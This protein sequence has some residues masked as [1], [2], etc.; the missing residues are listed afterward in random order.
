VIY[1][2]NCRLGDLFENRRQRGRPGLPLLSVTMNDGLVDRDDLE[3][4]QACA[5]IWLH[6]G[7]DSEFYFQY[8]SAQYEAIRELGNAGTQQNLN[9]AI[10][11]GLVVPVPPASEQ[12]RIVQ[13]LSTVDHAIRLSA[14]QVRTLKDEKTALMADLLT[15]KRRVR[16]PAAE[17]TP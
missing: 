4:K 16:V 10:L 15:G 12:R 3:R 9:G 6:E 7:Y 14:D 1:S 17:T 13:V 2:G 11:K 5:A 8:L